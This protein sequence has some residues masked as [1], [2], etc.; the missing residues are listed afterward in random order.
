MSKG[1]PSKPDQTRGAPSP[2]P[3]KTPS[4]QPVVK[5]QTGVPSS[6]PPSKPKK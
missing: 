5:P 2:P 4:Q 6:P 3:P 1:T